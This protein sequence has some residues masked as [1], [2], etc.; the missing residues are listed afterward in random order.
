MIPN[1]TK[2]IKFNCCIYEFLTALNKLDKYLKIKLVE[3]DN[4]LLI[5]K[6][7]IFEFLSVGSFITIYIDK[8]FVNNA[9]VTFECSRVVGAFDKNYEVQNATTEINTFIQKLSYLLQH[10]NEDT[11]IKKESAS[12]GSI[13]SSIAIIILFIGLLIWIFI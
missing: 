3:A 8:N 1:P 6:Y 11:P 10:P 13:A 2:T 9:T 7:H 4:S 5:Y 12:G